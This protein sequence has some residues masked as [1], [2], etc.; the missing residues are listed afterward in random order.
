MKAHLIERVIMNAFSIRLTGQR[1]QEECV[2]VFRLATDSYGRPSRCLE[3]RAHSAG[4]GWEDGQG[5]QLNDSPKQA[6][7][8]P[9][10]ADPNS[11]CFIIFILQKT[12][13]LE[14]GRGN[15]D[16]IEESL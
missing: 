12:L 3:G 9:L 15:R 2:V 5:C 13:C 6:K 14:K 11:S 1:E 8:K 10:L 16:F 7:T 4:N